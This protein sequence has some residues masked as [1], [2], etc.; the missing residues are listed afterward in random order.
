MG[1]RGVFGIGMMILGGIFALGLLAQFA[2]ITYTIATGVERQGVV[3][4][5]ATRP[6]AAGRRTSHAPVVR[7]VDELGETHHVEG[8]LGVGRGLSSPRPTHNVGDRVTVRYPA[9]R[10]EEA[11]ITGF[12]QH[13]SFFFM[14]LLP[15]MFVWIGFRNWRADKREQEE[16]G[17]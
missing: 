8:V 1:L 13:W 15:A 14:T 11:V 12:K 17:W 9:G 7:F 6:A 5:L 16:L 10:P 3:T 4:S 2:S